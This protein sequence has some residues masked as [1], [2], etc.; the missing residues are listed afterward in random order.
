MEQ[1]DSGR[2]ASNQ[3]RSLRRHLSSIIHPHEL[4]SEGKLVRDLAMFVA[5]RGLDLGGQCLACLIPKRTATWKHFCCAPGGTQSGVDVLERDQRNRPRHTFEANT[6]LGDRLGP[7]LTTLCFEARKA[8]NRQVPGSIVAIGRR[9]GLW[10]NK[11][12][13]CRGPRD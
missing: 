8:L 11:V 7:P 1:R 9:R 3:H 6:I 12:I 13:G 5:R 10:P 2:E 4:R